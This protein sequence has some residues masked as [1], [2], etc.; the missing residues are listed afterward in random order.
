MH[1]RMV[2]RSH[3]LC[4]VGL[5]LVAVACLCLSVSPAAAAPTKRPCLT[6]GIP[7]LSGEVK[8]LRLPGGKKPSSGEESQGARD[9]SPMCR[10][11]QTAECARSG[12]VFKKYP[13]TH[14]GI[15][16]RIK[17]GLSPSKNVAAILQAV[18]LTVWSVLISALNGVLMALEWAFSLKITEEAMPDLQRAMV[19]LHE[20]VFGTSWMLAAVTIAGLIGIYNGLLRR[21]TIQTMGALAV[22][23]FLMAAMLLVINRPQETIGQFTTWS[24]DA[25]LG[26]LGLGA[27]GT[28]EHGQASWAMLSESMFKNLGEQPWCELQFDPPQLCYG[29]VHRKDKRDP[30][31][32]ATTLVGDDWLS[33]PAWGSERAKLYDSYAAANSGYMRLQDERGVY[34]RVGILF[35]VVVAMVTTMCV[36]I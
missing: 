26:V 24:E 10:E 19:D 31:R 17:A 23:V 29:E 30:T 21:R 33:K 9:N 1:W 16:V 34:K 20:N 12:S 32:T 7:D 28:V 11:L 8:C 22:T 35:M 5:V 2:G 27:A 36:L 13:L 25:A 18:M 4:L 15:D 3:S 6:P 14:Y